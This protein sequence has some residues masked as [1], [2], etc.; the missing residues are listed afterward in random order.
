MKLAMYT[1]ETSNWYALLNRAQV[2]SDCY[3]NK[4]VENYLVY[5]LACM[6]S[7]I[8]FVP[9]KGITGTDLIPVTK[10]ESRLMSIRQIGE[11]SLVV[12]GLFPDYANRTGIPLLYLMEK[13]RSA[14]SE[15]ADACPNEFIYFYLGEHFVQVVDVLQKLGEIC[16]DNHSIDLLQ[17]YELWQET[18]SRHGWAV[19]HNNLGAFPAA[20]GS[21]LQH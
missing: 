19:I 17:A 5:V 12:T 20:A 8:D 9:G 10:R 6:S 15:L 3:F 7:G 14:Y 2:A 21:E 13:G 1:P 18:G 16:G 11:Q 4:N